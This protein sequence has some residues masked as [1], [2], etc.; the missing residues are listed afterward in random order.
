MKRNMI[1]LASRSDSTTESKSKKMH[2]SSDPE[3]NTLG[4]LATLPDYVLIQILTFLC[5]KDLHSVNQICRILHTLHLS[6]SLWESK[7]RTLSPTGFNSYKQ[8]QQYKYPLSADA[9]YKDLYHRKN[10]FPNPMRKKYIEIT[11]ENGANHPMLTE[12]FSFF[13]LVRDEITR[14]G[15]LDFVIRFYSQTILDSIF[16]MASAHYK[17]QHSSFVQKKFY[18]D[19]NY[20]L[21]QTAAITCRPIKFIEEQIAAGADVNH[22]VINQNSTLMLASR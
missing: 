14:F 1:E 20:T 2:Q 12:N 18:T 3:R 6:K 21:L 19:H 16:D 17:N 22:V 11:N 4:N 9:Y 15:T 13:E 8:F 5:I 7:L 10:E